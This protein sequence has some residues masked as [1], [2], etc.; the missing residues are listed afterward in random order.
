MKNLLIVQ[1]LSVP[2]II[3]KV[4]LGSTDARSSPVLAGGSGIMLQ[5]VSAKMKSMEKSIL[6]EGLLG[7]RYLH[8]HSSI[9]EGAQVLFHWHSMVLVELSLPSSTEVLNFA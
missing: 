2:D 7:V 4:V 9:E 3:D 6:V 5:C 1:V 8:T